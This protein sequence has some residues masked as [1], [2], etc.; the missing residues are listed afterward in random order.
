MRAISAA[1]ESDLKDEKIAI[2][3]FEAFPFQFE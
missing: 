1:H 2:A 3:P